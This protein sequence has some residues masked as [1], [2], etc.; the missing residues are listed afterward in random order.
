LDKQSVFQHVASAVTEK[1]FAYPKLALFKSFALE[2]LSGVDNRLRKDLEKKHGNKTWE[3]KN[4]I[5][6]RSKLGFL[7][8][9]WMNAAGYIITF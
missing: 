9:L 8:R 5:L 7:K 2:I 3:I 4:Q 1:H 6:P